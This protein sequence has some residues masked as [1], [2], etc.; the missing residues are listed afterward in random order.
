MRKKF[1]DAYKDSTSKSVEYFAVDFFKDV[2]LYYLLEI[3]ENTLV[4][5][6]ELHHQDKVQTLYL[7]TDDK[8]RKVKLS[9]RDGERIIKASS[10]KTSDINKISLEQRS[11]E[12]VTL[13]IE[14][15]DKS[16]I[17]LDSKNIFSHWQ[18]KARKVIK[19]IYKKYY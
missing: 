16:K 5:V 19:E 17:V 8:I 18:S 3:D 2:D 4:Y 15:K 9:I 7:F 14:L 13:T 10:I 1:M 11:Y 6:D 12:S